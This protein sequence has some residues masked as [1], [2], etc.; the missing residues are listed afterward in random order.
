MTWLMEQVAGW[1][2]RRSCFH[3]NTRNGQSF[4]RDQIIDWRKRYHCTNC[5]KVWV[6]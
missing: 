2:A 6:I 5:G 3:H 1:R 4:I